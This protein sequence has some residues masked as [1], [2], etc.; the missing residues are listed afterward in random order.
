[1]LADDNLLTGRLQN[2]VRSVLNILPTPSATTFHAEVFHTPADQLILCEIASRTGGARISDGLEAALGQNINRLWAR[3]ECGLD[4]QGDLADIQEA[5]S[6]SL[7]TGWALISP[8]PGK[9]RQLP[10]VC[11][12]PEVIDFTLNTKVGDVLSSPTAATQSIAS[13]V[14]VVESEEHAHQTIDSCRQWFDA[15]SLIEREAHHVVS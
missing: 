7:L 6:Q 14:F 15:H 12:L 2:F 13:F 9:I 4:V 10:S 3:Q 8:K 11:D 1:M 5:A